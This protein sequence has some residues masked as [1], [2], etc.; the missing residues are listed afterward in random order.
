MAPQGEGDGGPEDGVMCD[1]PR[2][3][4][5]L[6]FARLQRPLAGRH[7]VEHVLHQQ[8]GALLRCA[9]LALLQDAITACTKFWQWHTTAQDDTPTGSPSHTTEVTC[10]CRQDLLHGAST[11]EAVKQKRKL[12]IRVLGSRKVRAKTGDA[13]ECGAGAMQSPRSSR[14]H[15][16]M[17]YERDS[18]QGLSTEA[19]CADAFQV[20][21]CPQL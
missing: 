1:H 13:P 21:E 6:L 10:L 8:A 16:E 5:I 3:P 18:S 17:G 15:R 19:E 14:G 7:V 9:L 4:R 20:L 12:H 11:A 2:Q